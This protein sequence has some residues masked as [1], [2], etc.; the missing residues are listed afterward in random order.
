M[1]DK[2]KQAIG[3]L[4]LAGVLAAAMLLK[5]KPDT[6][7]AAD[8]SIAVLD[9]AG[10]EI[11]HSSPVPLE[12]GGFYRV[13]AVVTNKSTLQGEPV[14]ASLITTIAVVLGGT[15][16]LSTSSPGDYDAG[17][18]HGLTWT[19][20][21]PSD[22]AGLSGTI[23][24]AV[25]D[26]AGTNLAQAS[27][28]ITVGPPTSR[29]AINGMGDLDNDGYVTEADA[30]IVTAYYFGQP[31]SAISP[32]SLWEF[33]RRADLNCDSNIDTGD[34]TAI[35]SFIAYGALPDP[36]VG[37]RAAINGMGDLNDDGYVNSVDIMLCG[38]LLSLP[39]SVVSPL[40]EAEVLRRAD[41]TG[42]G[43]INIL[44]ILAITNF[45]NTG[46]LPQPPQ[47]V[48]AASVD[49]GVT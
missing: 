23:V 35:K 45:I 3:I 49:L 16:L 31:V 21:V 48:Y 8:I 22:A 37:S 11:P 38:A 1:D 28:D 32:L 30:N 10:N 40:S 20:N 14:A 2:N 29:P 25:F 34:I 27:L 46:E 4:S 39:A 47:I 15:T 12:P 19:L 6:V 44:D 24:V 7:T 26:H 5:K 13:R 18:A 36:V 42:D 41:L 43:Q 9:Q 17:E 33:V